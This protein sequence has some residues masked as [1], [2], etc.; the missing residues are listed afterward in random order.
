MAINYNLLTTMSAEDE[1]NLGPTIGFAK[2]DVL[3]MRYNGAANVNGLGE[4]NTTIARPNFDPN[5]G[6]GLSSY[7]HN[8]GRLARQINSTSYDIEYTKKW[9][10]NMIYNRVWKH[11]GTNF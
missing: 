9:Q 2:D 7:T 11:K 10:M 8:S 3:S 1:K 5:A 6:F 4:C